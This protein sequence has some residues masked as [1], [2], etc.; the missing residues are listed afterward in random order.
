MS[1]EFDDDYRSKSAVK[2]EYQDI[3][4]LTA[5]LIQLSP[6]ELEQIS[7]SPGLRRALIETTKMRKGAL[8]R[9][10]KFVTGLLAEEDLETVKRELFVLRQPS[11]ADNAQFHHLEEVRDRLAS[12]DDSPLESMQDQLESQQR[13]QLR[14]LVRN[15][16]KAG[17]DAQSAK[18]R[19]TLFRF[20]R[21][22]DLK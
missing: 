7:I 2:R 6:K 18:A 13:Q 8:Q 3:K 22:H 1:E 15:S 19:R 4:S 16:R 12:G 11:Q 20:L 5:E 9:Q 14:Q 21:D 10:L 17:N